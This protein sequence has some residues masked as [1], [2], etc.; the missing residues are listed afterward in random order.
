MRQGIVH[1]RRTVS[2]RGGNI[3]S[4]V[5]KDDVQHLVLMAT[6]HAQALAR[7]RVPHL[8]RPVHAARDY[9]GAVPVEL[10]AADLGL[11]AD[12]RVEALA[13]AHVPHRYRVV[14]GA[15]QNLVALKFMLIL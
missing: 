10:G 9:R 1:A 5:V 12:E 3:L 4:R 14:E 8:A 2:R 6:Q 7:A 11:V 13:T 15:R